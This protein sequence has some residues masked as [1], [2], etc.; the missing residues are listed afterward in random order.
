M[1]KEHELLFKPPQPTIS[2][3]DPFADDWLERR[4]Q[5]QNLGLVLRQSTHSVVCAVDGAWGAGKT[6]FLRRLR[7]HLES[8]GHAILWF[9]AWENDFVADP[10][11]ALIAEFSASSEL[12]DSPGA[13]SLERTKVLGAQ[14]VR[15]GLPLVLRA[16]TAGLVGKAELDALLEAGISEVGQSGAEYAEHLI[17]EYAESKKTLRSFKKSLE[18][19][20]QERQQAGTPLPIVFI[21][22]ELDRCR[23]DYAVLILERIKHLFAVP[24]VSFVLGMNQDQLAHSVRAVYG[25]GFDGHGYLE[26]LVDLRFRLPPASSNVFIRQTAEAA[27]LR[28]AAMHRGH[29]EEDHVVRIIEALRDADTFTPRLQQRCIGEAALILRVLSTS[30]FVSASALTVFLILR[31]INPELVAQ[32]VRGNASAK[33]VLAYLESVSPGWNALSEFVK[34]L[35]RA[36]LFGLS[37]HTDEANTREKQL[38]AYVPQATGQDARRA[39]RELEH[40]QHARGSKG[41]LQD[42]LTQMDFAQ[43]LEWRAPT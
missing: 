41:M 18:E 20:A 13:S 26:R 5:I 16:A 32:Y 28:A 4:P 8:K 30:A 40:L 31:R 9:D 11:V 7:A 42:M 33:D 15:R 1:Y 43:R 34:G 21:I 2:A 17:S 29:E 27:G 37:R 36:Y 35:V 22:D 24:G 14:L 39:E 25:S 38:E 3:D 6:T 12:G 10:L 23:P 19:Y